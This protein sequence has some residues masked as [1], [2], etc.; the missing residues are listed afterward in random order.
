MLKVKD[1]YNCDRLALAAG[2]A[3]IEDEEWMRKNAE[4]VRQTRGRLIA[5]LARLGFAVVPSQA[6][7]VWA[8]HPG[9]S[10]SEIYEALKGR[11]ILIRYMQFPDVPWAP[12]GLLTGLR[13]TVGTDAEIDKLISELRHI[14]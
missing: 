13:I 11:R 10:D 1:S 7:F 14:L 12:D 9:R 3:A 6:N 5:E 4:R 8:T 2:I